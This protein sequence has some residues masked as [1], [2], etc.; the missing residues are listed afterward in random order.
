MSNETTD[1]QVLRE[2]ER[3]LIRS[4][5]ER[6]E[7]ERDHLRARRHQSWGPYLL[8]AFLATGVVATFL[9]FFADLYQIATTDRDATRRANEKLTQQNVALAGQVKHL[10]QSSETAE[11]LRERLKLSASAAL[12]Q[13]MRIASLRKLAAAQGPAFQARVAE[14]EKLPLPFSLTEKTLHHAVLVMWWGLRP[15]DVLAVSL[16][17][18]RPE[19]HEQ[20]AFGAQLGDAQTELGLQT[21]GEWNAT[22]SLTDG[23]IVLNETW[24]RP[25]RGIAV[26]VDLSRGKVNG[27]WPASRVMNG[28]TERGTAELL[29]ANGPGWT[30]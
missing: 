12:A 28:I 16:N 25:R 17:P 6:N 22:W 11:M 15:G 26:R 1:D 14:V 29:F 9:G 24:P 13:E 8:A 27:Y 3:A 7:A 2:L 21:G 20:F 19:D 5:I 18:R 10:R 30:K 4:E 23:A